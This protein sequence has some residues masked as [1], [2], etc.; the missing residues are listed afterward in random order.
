M[1]NIFKRLFCKHKYELNRWHVCHG[2]N[3]DELS[4]IEAEYVCT[5]CG[6]VLYSDFSIDMFKYFETIC[7]Q[8]ERRIK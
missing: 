7:P 4:M 3:G 2:P 8:Y 5:K 6:H 1:I